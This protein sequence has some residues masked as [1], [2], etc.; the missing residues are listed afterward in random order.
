[1][2]PK[3]YYY[4]KVVCSFFDFAAGTYH[5]RT[6]YHATRSQAFEVFSALAQ[7]YHWEILGL[8]L[9]ER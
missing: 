6:V 4:L 2:K 5:K 3:D 8:D 1:M 9:I 7:V